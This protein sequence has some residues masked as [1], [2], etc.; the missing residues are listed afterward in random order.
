MKKKKGAPPK[1]T[2]DE[3]RFFKQLNTDYQI[4]NLRRKTYLR[5]L[6]VALLIGI[7]GVVIVISGGF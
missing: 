7:V 6:N 4:S 2:R 3:I 5:I 1:F